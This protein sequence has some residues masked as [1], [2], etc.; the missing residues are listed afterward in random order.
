MKRNGLHIFI[1]VFQRVR[2]TH[3]SVQDICVL[4]NSMSFLHTRPT[5]TKRLFLNLLR[6]RRVKIKIGKCEVLNFY[7]ASIALHYKF[8]LQRNLKI[9]LKL[10]L[11][12][13]E[14]I[15]NKLFLNFKSIILIMIMIIQLISYFQ[16]NNNNNNPNML[17][18]VQRRCLHNFR[19]CIETRE[20]DHI[21][22]VH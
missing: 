11:N 4:K 2:C 20:I 6:T 18:R 7:P 10:L 16:A 14:Q 22:N 1:D 5:S 13:N 19:K 3:L 9:L 21:Q 12:N 17:S 15:F 8:I